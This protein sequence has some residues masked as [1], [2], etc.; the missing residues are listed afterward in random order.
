MAGPRPAHL[1]LGLFLSACGGRSEVATEA[2]P[3]VAGLGT[4]ESPAAQG[5]VLMRALRCGACHEGAGPVD[6][7]PDLTKIGERLD[8]DYVARFL[9]DPHGV[10]PGTVMPDLARGRSTAERGADAHALAAFLFSASGA[11]AA[12]GD[13]G[14]GPDVVEAGQRHYHELGCAACHAPLDGPDG[15]PDGSAPMADVAQKYHLEGLRAFLLDPLEHRASGRMPDLALTP[16]EAH[17]IAVAMGARPAKAVDPS[18]EAFVRSGRERFV[19]LG[20]ASC[21]AGIA[22]GA[23][24]AARPLAALDASSKNG[25]LS[26]EVGVW[27]SFDL[28]AEQIAAV[29][30][31]LGSPETPAGEEGIAEW[32]AARQ[33][34]ACHAR[35][36]RGGV[37][38]SRD[39][40]FTTVDERTGSASRLPPPLD[41]VGEKLTPAWLHR[42]IAHGQEQRAY[43]TTRMPG[44]GAAFAGELAA[45]L[46]EAD[47]VADLEFPPAPESDEDRRAFRDLGMTLVGDQGLN[48][49]ACHTFGGESVGAMAAIDLAATTGERLTRGFF[50]RYLREPTRYRPDTLMPT[51]FAGGKS[52]LPELADGDI[53]RQIDAMWTYLAEGRN[54]RKP[55]GLRSPPVVLAVEDRPVILRRKLQRTGKRGIS[56]GLPGGVNFA[57]DAE[58]LALHQVWWGDFLDASP[59]FHGQGSGEARILGRDLAVLPLGPA[60]VALGS[61]EEPWPTATRRELGHELLGY[62]L[63]ADGYPTFRYSLPGVSIEDT[64]RPAMREGAPPDLV[65]KI[66]FTRGEGSPDSVTALVARDPKLVADGTRFRIGARLGV[67]IVGAEPVLLPAGEELELRIPVRIGADPAEISITYSLVEEGR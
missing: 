35:G 50:H 10:E 18:D 27:P 31:A 63:D 51:F 40:F 17:A 22:D 16:A 66:R 8:R 46:T 45:R 1:L 30:A 13:L 57:F 59:V 4:L 34:F 19:A 20:C 5:R 39:R 2:A 55:R 43:V 61:G 29:R 36:G 54:T 47:K 67:A 15:D 28:D 42:A 33:C 52:P 41:H 6:P 53:T 56:V 25:C 23:A 7:G 49:I 58:T 3:H 65:R 37:V 38:A 48:C 60:V 11:P 21:H 12:A 64:A 9:I 62:D 14:S 26:G 44:F 24:S 32:M